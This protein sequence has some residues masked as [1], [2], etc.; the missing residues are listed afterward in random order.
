MRG[1]GCTLCRA[2]CDVMLSRLPAFQRAHSSGTP[3]LHHGHV[4]AMRDVQC[5]ASCTTSVSP[6]IHIVALLERL[7]PFP[8]TFCGCRRYY[9]TQ[10]QRASLWRLYIRLG[11]RVYDTEG[12]QT[13]EDGHS[14]ADGENDGQPASRLS[15]TFIPI[16]AWMFS[17]AYLGGFG[18][19]RVHESRF[20]GEIGRA[21]ARVLQRSKVS[22]HPATI[23]ASADTALDILD[24]ACRPW[25]CCRDGARPRRCRR[26]L[27]RRHLRGR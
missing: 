12:G 18:D 11:R 16:R 20:C 17:S 26:C 19:V 25:E 10:I 5:L 9:R 15:D 7:R 24:G 3:S 27:C 1:G 2:C 21:A 13:M 22:Q 14:I 4:L 8:P 6:C 23:T